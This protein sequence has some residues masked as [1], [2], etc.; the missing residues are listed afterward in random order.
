MDYHELNQRMMQDK[1][2]IPV[3]DELLDELCGVRIFTKLDLRSDY[4]QVRMHPNDIDKMTFHTH[5]GH[6]E[7]LVMPFGLSNAPST[8][9]SLMNEVLQPFLR[10]F[11]L[12]FFDD[13][14]MFSRSCSEHLQHV[15]QVFQALRYHKLALKWSKCYSGIET[16][17][18]L[19]HIISVNGVAMDPTKVE[20]VEAWPSLCSLRAL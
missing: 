1:F 6:F 10:K 3:V 8:F 14:L 17:A 11:V 19:G 12:I 9:Q 13:I 15:K 7:F 5:R 18:Y 20:A 4:H 2:P 16:V